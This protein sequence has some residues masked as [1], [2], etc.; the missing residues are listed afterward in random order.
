VNTSLREHGLDVDRSHE[1]ASE[2]DLIELLAAD[3]G[4]AVMRML[5]SA[6]GQQLIG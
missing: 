6:D 5:R 3:I 2:R 1:I 4:V